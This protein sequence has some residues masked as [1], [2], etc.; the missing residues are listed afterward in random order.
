M[1]REDMERSQQ[2][3]GSSENKGESRE[4][5]KNKMTSI[6]KEERQDIAHEGGLGRKRISDLKETDAFKQKDD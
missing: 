3:T 1:K 6:D 5:Q 4:A 2:G